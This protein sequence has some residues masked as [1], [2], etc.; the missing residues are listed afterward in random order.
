MWLKFA[1]YADAVYIAQPLAAIRVHNSTLSSSVSPAQWCQEYL[2]IM[3]QGVALAESVDPS[4]LGTKD[5]VLHE[6][7]RAQGKRFFIAAVA[8]MAEGSG[9]DASGYIEVLR[10]LQA[11]GLPR[12][13]AR[14]AQALR[15]PLGQRLLMAVRR[16]RK[17]QAVQRLP[18]EAPWWE[19]RLD[20][21]ATG[22]P[23]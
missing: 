5:Q 16:F 14:L 1:L 3:E 19:G 18:A 13:Y 17:A 10:R 9:T 21:A 15:N 2:A 23:R 6:A 4:L 22:V 20:R 8:A 12:V 11:R 7:I